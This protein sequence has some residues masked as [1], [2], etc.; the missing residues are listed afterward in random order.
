MSLE[1]LEFGECGV[2]SGIGEVADIAQG[3][4]GA[5]AV[6]V[7]GIS[8]EYWGIGW[9]S[10][11][12]ALLEKGCTDFGWWGFLLS[13]GSFSFRSFIGLGW[14]WWEQSLTSGTVFRVYM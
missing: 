11:E 10:A 7:A 1:E 6:G 14:G 13:L 9:G 3:I 5:K 8:W 2:D 4:V 12:W